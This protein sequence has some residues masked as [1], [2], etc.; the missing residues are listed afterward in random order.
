ME[1]YILPITLKKGENWGFWN[2]FELKAYN[3]RPGLWILK[4]HHEKSFTQLT[5]L[6]NVSM[7][8]FIEQLN[9]K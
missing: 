1:K 3:G 9:E 5:S 8:F 6:I 7:L 4:D 2:T